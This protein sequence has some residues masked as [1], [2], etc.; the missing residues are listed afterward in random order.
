MSQAMDTILRTKGFNSL[1]MVPSD[2]INCHKTT[3]LRNPTDRFISA[4]VMII[5]DERHNKDS[6]FKNAS[7][8]KENLKA[9]IGMLEKRFFDGHLRPQVDY[10]PM[11]MDK[12]LIQEKIGKELPLGAPQEFYKNN[13]LIKINAQSTKDKKLV[14]SQLDK[15]LL[16][17][18]NKIYAEDWK[19]YNSQNS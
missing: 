15:T 12:Y 7:L 4:Y 18:L 19:L 13:K 11:K 9:F 16:N 8:T 17:K 5:T 6:I 3:I 10:L 2:A 1:S 14:K